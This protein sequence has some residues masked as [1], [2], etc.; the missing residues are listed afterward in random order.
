MKLW[1]N[2]PPPTAS[3]PLFIGALRPR[4]LAECGLPHVG[5]LECCSVNSLF[6]GC[7]G[8]NNSGHPN[9]DV[10]Y[11]KLCCGALQW[12]SCCGLIKDIQSRR[13][14]GARSWN[15]KRHWWEPVAI[16]KTRTYE[17]CHHALNILWKMCPFILAR[18]ANA[19]LKWCLLITRCPQVQRSHGSPSIYSSVIPMAPTV[20]NFHRRVKLIGE[21]VGVKAD[22]K[23]LLLLG[24]ACWSK[25]KAMLLW[26]TQNARP[27]WK[28]DR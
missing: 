26:V 23:D 8:M 27:W 2:P 24:M 28:G 18:D 21:C 12:K 22:W 1:V 3:S 19:K 9:R 5:S 11:L 7:A 4:R 14:Y 25:P 17:H 16:K 20:L 15:C 6:M 10:F 13:P